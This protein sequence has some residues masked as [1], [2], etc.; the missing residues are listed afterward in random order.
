MGA[1]IWFGRQALVRLVELRH[2]VCDIE[3]WLRRGLRKVLS[4]LRAGKLFGESRW[5]SQFGLTRLTRLGRGF[6]QLDGLAGVLW[7][8]WLHLS[9]LVGL[10]DRRCAS[11]RRRRDPLP[12]VFLISKLWRLFR[13]WNDFIFLGVECG[14]S[15]LVFVFGYHLYAFLIR[16]NLRYSN[17]RL[18]LRIRPVTVFLLASSA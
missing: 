5:Y 7:S 16:L 9:R 17:L 3:C 14:G 4:R 13:F 1:P 12:L 10:V 8:D 2:E 11:R 18:V 6:L 15:V